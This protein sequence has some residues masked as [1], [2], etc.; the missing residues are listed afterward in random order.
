MKTIKKHPITFTSLLT[1][2]LLVVSLWVT[3]V[4]VSLAHAST[5]NAYDAVTYR[6]P[7][8][9]E[10]SKVIVIQN[11]K[12]AWMLNGTTGASTAATTWDSAEI[13]GTPDTISNDW[14]FSVPAH[15]VHFCSMKIYDNVAAGDIYKTTTPSS[16]CL[17]NPKEGLAYTDTNPLS[18]N[19]VRTTTAN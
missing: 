7:F 4:L 17:Y 1:L 9:G 2:L 18:D 10:T 16:H 12:S 3:A 19:Q 13:T 6:I 15:N 14:L 8:N 5:T 11:R